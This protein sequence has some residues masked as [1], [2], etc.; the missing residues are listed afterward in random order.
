MNFIDRTTGKRVEQ[1]EQNTYR[2]LDVPYPTTIK[3]HYAPF[4]MPAG[5]L[6]R[7]RRT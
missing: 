2:L 4:L 6:N 1:V 7:E 5:E 3:T